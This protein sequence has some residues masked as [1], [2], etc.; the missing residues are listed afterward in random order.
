MSEPLNPFVTGH[1]ANVPAWIADVMKNSPDNETRQDHLNA[2]RLTWWLALCSAWEMDRQGVIPEWDAFW[3]EADD[4]DEMM[5]DVI[6]TLA[7]SGKDFNDAVREA[8]ALLAGRPPLR[9][10]N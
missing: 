5:D 9:V 1:V 7:R 2:A 4:C 3:A 6:D 8:R 10:V